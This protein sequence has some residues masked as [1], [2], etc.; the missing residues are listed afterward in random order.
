MNHYILRSLKMCISKPS[1]LFQ[2]ELFQNKLLFKT[3][4]AMLRKLFKRF[5][6]SNKSI[7]DVELDENSKNILRL[8]A[9]IL[10]KKHRKEDYA[11]DEIFKDPLLLIEW[12]EPGI[13]AR[14]AI[15]ALFTKDALLNLI[16]AQVGYAPFPPLAPS[17]CAFSFN[18]RQALLNTIAVLT[19]NNWS[20]HANGLPDVG[21]CFEIGVPRKGQLETDEHLIAFNI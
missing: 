15:N 19:N 2:N 16:R 21:R 18:D 6:K 17:N 5:N 11:D 3:M 10:R 9:K 13:L 1:K 4:L 14:T 12:N 7:T 20:R 8:W